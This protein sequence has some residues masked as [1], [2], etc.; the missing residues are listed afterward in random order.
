MIAII[1]DFPYYTNDVRRNR[2]SPSLS[3][4]C[5]SV[6]F[7]MSFDYFQVCLLPSHLLLVDTLRTSVSCFPSSDVSLWVNRKEYIFTFMDRHFVDWSFY[8]YFTFC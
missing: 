2:I 3:H 6:N 7:Q 4:H 8:V 5:V 1:N